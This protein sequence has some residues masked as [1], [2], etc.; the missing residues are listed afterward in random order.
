MGC[1]YEILTVTMKKKEHMEQFIEMFNEL[2]KEDFSDEDFEISMDD[3]EEWDRQF[4]LQVDAEPLFGMYE[5]GEQVEYIVCEF[6][7]KVP[8]AECLVEYDCTF[9]NCADALYMEIEY[10]GQKL[11]LTRYYGDAAAID[12]CPECN[13]DFDE[14]LCTLKDYDPEAD[15]SCPECNAKLEMDTGKSVEEFILVNGEW[16]L[17]E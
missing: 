6:L 10:K 16:E 5:E 11:M 7:K 14:P 15:Y 3:V 12:Y 8:M 2:L 1:T 13:A 9:N 17:Q 4:Q